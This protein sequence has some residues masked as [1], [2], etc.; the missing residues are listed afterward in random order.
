MTSTTS[1]SS[2]RKA[3]CSSEPAYQVGAQI[4]HL[5]TVGKSK[6]GESFKRTDHFG[7]ELKYFSGCILNDREPEPDG[8]EGMLDVR[9]IA[10]AEQS[11]LT[12]SVQTL[13][14]FRR[15]RRAA[16]EQVEKL[17]VTHEPELI[18]VHQPSKGR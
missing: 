12:N 5:L 8:E 13:T 1:A 11:L 17:K 6:S 16:P 18:A 2:A 7:G 14:P 4:K 3:I 10:A 15:S 9:V